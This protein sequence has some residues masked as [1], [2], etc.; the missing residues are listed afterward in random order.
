[1]SK[2]L[3]QSHAKRA[4]K[5]EANDDCIACGTCVQICPRGNIKLEDG[6]PVFGRN[7]I[8]CLS[9][10]QFCPKQAINIGSI[11]EKR[12]RF[13]NPRVKASELSEKI[14]QID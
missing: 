14:I 5:I 12:E 3:A 1:M 13:P 6:K 8:G 4:E 9:C 2:G 10:V 11:T 7:C